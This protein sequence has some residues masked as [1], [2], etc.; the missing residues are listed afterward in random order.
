MRRRGA[1]R[2][3]RRAA[4]RT[5]RRRMILPVGRRYRR[6]RILVG[7]AT[8]LL[9]GGAAYKMGQSSVQQIEQHTGKPADQLSQEELE[10]AMDELGIEEQ[11]LTAEDQAA[12]EAEAVDAPASSPQTQQAAPPPAPSTAQA[13]QPDYIEELERLADLAEKGIITDEEFQAKKKQLLG[14]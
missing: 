14:L 9:V 7:G 10:T 4:R 1:R 12:I 13:A 8:L 11:E 3:G 5:M 2:A 6:R